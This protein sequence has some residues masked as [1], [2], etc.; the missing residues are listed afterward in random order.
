MQFVILVLISPSEI[1]AAGRSYNAYAAKDPK[2]HAYWKTSWDVIVYYVMKRAVCLK[3]DQ[4]PKLRELLLK[5]GD[6]ELVE[7]SKHDTNCGIGFSA[8]EIKDGTA[9]HQ[10]KKWGGNWLGKILMEVRDFYR[11][12]ENHNGKLD[13]EYFDAEERK[14]DEKE[15]QHAV[16]TAQRKEK[17][18]ELR[19]K[20]SAMERGKATSKAAPKAASKAA[21]KAAAAP[22]GRSRPKKVALPQSRDDKLIAQLKAQQAKHEASVTRKAEPS[23]AMDLLVGGGSGSGHRRSRHRGR[24]S[25]WAASQRDNGEEDEEESGEEDEEENEEEDEEENGE[26][27][28]DLGFGTGGHV[29]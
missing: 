29:S 27:H 10:R 12:Q 16:A 22:R 5:T 26:E 11:K 19:E 8:S 4:N 14:Y 9:L 13:R 25:D 24:I 7:A 28:V 1:A 23:A 3:F 21:S 17:Q 2:W 18:A 6:Y 15:A 20:V